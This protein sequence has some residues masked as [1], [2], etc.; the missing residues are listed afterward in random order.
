[1]PFDPPRM[2]ATLGSATSPTL[3]ATGTATIT[4]TAGRTVTLNGQAATRVTEIVDMLFQVRPP[5]R[6]ERCYISINEPN[7]TGIAE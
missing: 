3:A 7:L 1:M 4:D 5:T 2:L 6:K